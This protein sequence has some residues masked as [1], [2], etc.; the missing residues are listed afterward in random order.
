MSLFHGR[1]IVG[2]LISDGEAIDRGVRNF[3]DEME[4]CAGQIVVGEDPTE[5]L[6]HLDHCLSRIRSTFIVRDSNHKP[7]TKDEEDMGF[8]ADTASNAGRFEAAVLAGADG[9]FDL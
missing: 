2:G 4:L 9:S 7:K 8:D 5:S 1:A 3:V 6:T